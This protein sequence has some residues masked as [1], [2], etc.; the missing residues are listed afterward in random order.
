MSGCSA[1]FGGTG[2]EPFFSTG[3]DLPDAPLRLLDNCFNLLNILKTL[4]PKISKPYRRLS[5]S[6]KDFA[7]EILQQFGHLLVGEFWLRISQWS[8][9][10]ELTTENTFCPVPSLA[11][12]HDFSLNL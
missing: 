3:S 1:W 12:S 4:A 11:K 10:Y 8:L 7:V 6:P 5:R 9:D 2:A